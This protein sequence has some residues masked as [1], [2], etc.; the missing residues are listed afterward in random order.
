MINLPQVSIHEEI[1]FSVE[2]EVETGLL[3]CKNNLAI[4]V[5]KVYSSFLEQEAALVQLWSPAG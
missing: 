5:H 4:R 1:Q 3:F 2:N